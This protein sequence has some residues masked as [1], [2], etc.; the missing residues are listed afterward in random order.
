GLDANRPHWRGAETDRHT[1][2][3]GTRLGVREHRVGDSLRDVH[4][5]KS[6][7]YD[8]LVV[9]ERESA[10]VESVTVS[11][12]LHDPNQQDAKLEWRLRIAASVC[13]S[14]A[15]NQGRVELWCGGTRLGG[16]HS[17]AGLVRTFDELARFQ[18]NRSAGASGAAPGGSGAGV[19]ITIDS[20][21]DAIVLRRSDLESR[22]RRGAEPSSDWI[23]VTSLGDAPDQV[24]RGW[25]NEVRRTSG[26]G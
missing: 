9:S 2:R 24:L 10:T 23:E 17:S 1:G 13:E 26:V 14:F 19:A 20:R 18:P 22:G 8:R 25:R 7:R 5:A 16:G 3:Q 21:A 4:W 11:V 15:A 12:P 6:A